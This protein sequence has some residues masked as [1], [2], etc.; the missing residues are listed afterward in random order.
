MDATTSNSFYYFFSAAPQVLGG[1]L[2]LFGFF[3]VFKIQS[4]KDELLVSADIVLQFFR[5]EYNKKDSKIRTPQML[6]I[7]NQLKKGIQDKNI[8]S[9]YF[10]IK[11]CDKNA[12]NNGEKNFLT[13]DFL[14]T[15]DFYQKLK[16]STLRLSILT[17]III[18]ECLSVLPYAKFIFSRPLLLEGLFF[19][20]ILLIAM[21][22][23][24]LILILYYALSD[25]SVLEELGISSK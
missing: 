20:T 9:L 7:I 18:L 1:I 2:A 12:K 19:C 6:L 3:L 14:H 13:M 22:F 8:R 15:Y 23:I 5:G 25:K 10:V 4:L 21:C 16:K 17:I 24:G 11:I